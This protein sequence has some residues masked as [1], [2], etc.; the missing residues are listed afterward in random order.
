[1][2]EKP[3]KDGTKKTRSG[4]VH[5]QLVQTPHG[6]DGPQTFGLHIGP[7][8]QGRPKKGKE[9]KTNSAVIVSATTTLNSCYAA[10]LATLATMNKE[11]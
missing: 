8:A 6:M 7:E 3:P 10:L 11:E 9:N 1:M 4:Q 5:L 2:E